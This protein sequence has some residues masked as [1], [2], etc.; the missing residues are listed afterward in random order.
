MKNNLFG[1]EKRDLPDFSD[2]SRKNVGVPKSNTSSKNRSDEIKADIERL[3]KSDGISR[4]D[5]AKLR[6]K[7][8]ND[9][10]IVDNIL[11][12]NMKR[13]KK[14]VEMAQKMA[15]KIHK[16][17]LKNNKPLHTM[18]Q[19][20]VQMKK[21]KGWT[22]SEFDEFKKELTRRLTGRHELEIV[23]NQNLSSY[24]S[25]INNAIGYS[26]NLY[27]ETEDI[28]AKPDDMPIISEIISL[29]ESTIQLHRRVFMSSLI[30][31]DCG[32]VAM[33]GEFKRD[34]HIA[35]NHIHPLIACMFLPKLGI[36]E[37]HML[38]SNIGS[39]VKTRYHKKQI[40]S[41]P[42]SL[43]FYEMISDP[44]DI[45][46]DINSPYVDLLNRFKVQVELWGLVLQLREG[47]YYDSTSINSFMKSLNT[48]RNNLYDNADL[49]YTQDEGSMLRRLL[50][51][52]SLRPILVRTKSINSL[53]ALSAFPF[54]MP[55]AT[56][57]SGLDVSYGVFPF[58]NQPM[59]T[60][61]SV[62]MIT[63]RIPFKTE[64]PEPIN[65]ATALSQ[66]LWVNEKNTIV[67]KE[68]SILHT[69]E[70]LIFYVNRRTQTVRLRTFTN[71]IPFS[72][73][74]LTMS[75]FE[76]LNSYPINIPPALT[77]PGSNELYQLRSVVAV[78]ETSIQQ[79]ETYTSIITGCTGL[80][81]SHTDPALGIYNTQHYIYDPVGASIP[82]RHPEYQSGESG[83]I[84]NKPIS[85]IDPVY[86]SVNN[87]IENK[88]FFER[89][90]TAGTIFIYA[91]PTGY[92]PSEIIS[93]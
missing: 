71:P 34:R 14:T 38:Y 42:D 2:D 64:N 56:S 30:Y 52:F 76:T 15:E 59:Y 68:Q 72:Q 7:Y 20:L 61:T 23:Y 86:T 73:T 74:P 81:I 32:L 18:L 24:R 75:N 33:T 11:N 63:L 48:C 92:N 77:L 9:D 31:N 90:S 46:C 4:A 53:A 49:A 66:T 12:H 13:H 54:N 79:R 35:S 91:K 37:T 78:S 50:S 43:L 62:S 41:E 69:K 10:A 8:N 27:Q 84:V 22:D 87:G 3:S 40:L 58:S 26:R 80:I 44:N 65:L 6:E 25:K 36:F 70:V 57:S 29:F 51:V 89:A 82:V 93:I 19:K 16:S 39:I 47:Q 1:G 88:S 45:V 85:L 60:I 5:I 83:F 21:E 28:N 55:L 67:P 17:M